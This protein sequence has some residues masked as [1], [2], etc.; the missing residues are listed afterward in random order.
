MDKK[1]GRRNSEPHFLS[2]NN[3]D[4]SNK[5]LFQQSVY[6]TLKKK[7]KP[8]KKDNDDDSNINDDEKNTLSKTDIKEINKLK[9]NAT[10][11]LKHGSTITWK[12]SQPHQDH[13]GAKYIGLSPERQYENIQIDIEDAAGDITDHFKEYGVDKYLY[14]S[15][16]ELK[17]EFNAFKASVDIET[18]YEEESKCSQMFRAKPPNKQAHYIHR[19][20]TVTAYNVYFSQIVIQ[21]RSE[22]LE[23]PKKKQMVIWC[24]F[25]FGYNI[26]RAQK[27]KA[28]NKI[29]KLYNEIEYIRYGKIILDCNKK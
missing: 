5:Y 20:M 25:Y 3:E 1:G 14:S 6:V 2:Y 21:T 28:T 24:K 27:D 13:P 17:Q 4:L 11:F 18:D 29:I 16:T 15:F 9:Q 7:I 22:A 12:P 10:S 8:P 19:G 26:I 23:F